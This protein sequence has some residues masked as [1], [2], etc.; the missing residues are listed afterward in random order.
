MTDIGSAAGIG[1]LGTGGQA[2]ELLGYCSRP[3]VFCAVERRFL[4]ARKGDGDLIDIESPGNDRED[5]EVVAAVGAP[6]LKRRLV[7]L[8]PGNRYVR[9][10]S[11]DATV[12]ESVG[13]GSGCVL[14][15]GARVMAEAVLGA[16]VLVNTNAV[17]SHECELGSYT[18]VSPGASLGGA[19]RVGDGV[20]IGIG[21]T[22]MNGI[23]IGEG[24]VVG[25]GAVVLSDVPPYEVVVG[26][27]ARTTSR[28]D[29][30]LNV[31]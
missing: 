8:W 22:V 7:E 26:V 31:I 29:T 30:W 24:A 18:T 9:V 11:E 15:P 12:A 19:C 3:V 13:L 6:G 2:R 17:V 25:A 21:A 5:A 20:F 27:P 4:G 1:L 23:A 28:R 14:A 10:V 16:H